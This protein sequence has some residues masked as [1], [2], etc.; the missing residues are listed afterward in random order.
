MF[1]ERYAQVPDGQK[2]DMIVH[3]IKKG[4]TL[5][6]IAQRYGIPASVIEESNRI[7]S[8]R[9]LSVGKNLIIPVP[10]G[11]DRFAS[12][13]AKSAKVD[14]YS[15]V[16]IAENGRRTNGKARIAR[17]LVLAQKRMPADHRDKTR[18]VY[19]VKRGDTIGHIAEW[20][21]VRAA[22]IRNWNDLPYGRTIRAGADLTI[23][24]GNRTAGRY[25]RINEM[26]FA[27]KQ[28]T[29]ARAPSTAEKED[30]ATEGSDRHVVRKG[31]TLGKIAAAHGVTIAQLKRWNHLKTARINAGQQLL[32]HTD[33]SRLASGKPS[34]DSAS[35]ERPKN[36]G[37]VVIYRVKKGDTLWDIAR[38]HNVEPSDLKTWNDIARNKIFAGQEL[39]IHVGGTDLHQ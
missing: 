10:R 8:A 9:R 7:P 22:D 2:R 35:Q 18:F 29:V 26:S 6:S 25:V 17:A 28:A 33:A 32:V 34:V 38:A 16:R 1:K 27:E 11:S 36:G 12:L 21:G 30:A 15:S 31:E 3:R 20:Y 4:E 14:A 39:I 5:S 13:V 37:R 19:T 23:W 24:V